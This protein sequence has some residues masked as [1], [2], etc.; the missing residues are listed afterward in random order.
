M[1]PV[2][3]NSPVRNCNK[4]YSSYR[5]YKP[6]LRKDFFNSCGY[7]GEDDSYFGGSRGFHIDHFR[8]HSKFPNLKTDYNNLAYSCP[9]CNVAKSNDWPGDEHNNIGNGVGY[10]DPCDASFE[11]HLTRHQNGRI[12]PL[13]NI[14]KYMYNEL[15]LGLKRKQYVWLLNE[16]DTVMDEVTSLLNSLSIS[17]PNR[18]ALKNRYI[19]LSMHFRSLK[20][21]YRDSLA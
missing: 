3:N 17:D 1:P 6:Y 8:P 13:T 15:H 9:F 11:K 2:R 20:K 16:L 14:G 12:E 5:S 21:I 10:I 18:E 19:E 4:A 7:C